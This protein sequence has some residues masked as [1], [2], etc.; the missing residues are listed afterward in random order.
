M[1]GAGVYSLVAC[2]YVCRRGWVDLDSV[3]EFG[4]D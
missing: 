4:K 1:H 3:W 2:R